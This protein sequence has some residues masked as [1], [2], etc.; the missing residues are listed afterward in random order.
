MKSTR[1]T[2]KVHPGIALALLRS[3]RDQDTPEESLEDEAFADSL[4]RR[5][6][7]S[8]VVNVQMRR[9]AD[10]RDRGQALELSEF[11]D[12][13]RLISRRPD[14]RSIFRNA[15][16]ALAIERFANLGPVSRAFR[17]FYSEDFRRRKLMRSMSKAARALSPGAR[18][19][20]EQDPPSME[21]E[22]CALAPAGIHG[23]A[24]EIL[25]GALGVC[26]AETWDPDLSIQHTECLGR[27]GERCAWSLVEAAEVEGTPG[28][29]TGF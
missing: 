9:Y 23:N 22:N 10:L 16:E 14:A 26:V 20:A 5:L 24:C 29:P 28:S 25:T 4:P 2:S 17:R 15:G 7:L 1:S 8:D 13:T 19:T 27:G 21:L 6:G 11:L 18:I 12:L 3:L